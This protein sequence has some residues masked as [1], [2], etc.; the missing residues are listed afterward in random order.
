LGRAL[1]T[2]ACNAGIALRARLVK[3]EDDDST[4]EVRPVD[5]D[6]ISR[7]WKRTEGFKLE[8]DSAGDR[9]VSSASLTALQKRDEIDEVAEGARPVENLF[10]KDQK[11]FFQAFSPKRTSPRERRA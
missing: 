7:E 1:Q 8:A 11:R 5:S 4:V 2:I 9:V 6:A 3:G 10:T